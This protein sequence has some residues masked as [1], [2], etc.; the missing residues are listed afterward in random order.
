MSSPEIAVI[1]PVFNG[2][3]YLPAC[4][5]SIAAQRFADFVCVLVDDGS[6]DKTP[7]L[8]DDI[9][10][11][12]GRFVV[13]HKRNGGAAA[14][15]LTGVQTARAYH[16]R[17]FAF[18]DA[19]DLLHPDFL[20][21]LHRAAA[22]SDM[23]IACCRREMFDD[24]QT[25][26]EAPLPSKSRLFAAPDHLDALLHNHSMDFSLCNKLYTA[27]LPLEELLDN[28]VLYN[29][30]LMANWRIFLLAKGCVYLPFAGYR[31]RQHAASISHALPPQSLDDQRAVALH[32]RESVPAQWPALQQSADAFYYE[33]LV[34][35]TSMILRREDITPYRVQYGEMLIAISSGLKDRRLG[36]NPRL[37]LVMRL[38]AVATVRYPALW[39]KLCRNYLKDRQ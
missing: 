39:R 2:A 27:D 1:V 5:E 26:A 38:S 21:E 9:A 36:R 28:N 10:A 7:A 17:W 23:P 8:C 25:P 31:Y 15:R 16:P 20:G 33:K 35:L 12:D 29:E 14:A 18:C 32:I 11:G 30:D 37:P 24:G 6:T 19:D 13:V 22:E 34:Y 4:V 3:T